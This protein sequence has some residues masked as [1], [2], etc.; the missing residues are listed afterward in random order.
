MPNA[1][2]RPHQDLLR[3]LGE[4]VRRLRKQ[5]GLTQEK[6]AELIDVHPRMVQKIEYGQSNILVTTA[7][8]LRDALSCDWDELLSQTVGQKVPRLSGK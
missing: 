8:R 6:L 7:M 5:K 2:H 1:S 4:N 3:K